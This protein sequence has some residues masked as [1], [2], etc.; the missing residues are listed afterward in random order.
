MEH[1]E[2]GVEGVG[3]GQHKT[4]APAGVHI[5]HVGER[6]I[7]SV[8]HSIICLKCIWMEHEGFDIPTS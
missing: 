7:F 6:D 1:S 8:G 2:W 4:V 5:S 3:K